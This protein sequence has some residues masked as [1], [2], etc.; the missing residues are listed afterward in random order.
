MGL[1][2][3]SPR[4]Q[5]GA[6]PPLSLRQRLQRNV[7]KHDIKQEAK[8]PAAPDGLE[9]NL[10]EVEVEAE[11]SELAPLRRQ[12]SPL[13]LRSV[14]PAGKGGHQRPAKTRGSHFVLYL[15]FHLRTKIRVKLH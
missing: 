6:Q 15:S 12:Q 9:T 14:Q 4:L 13:F 11:L 10:A 5:T 2:R 8:A 7:I 3:R 1:A